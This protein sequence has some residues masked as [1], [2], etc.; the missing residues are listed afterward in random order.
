MS[1]RDDRL[2][3]RDFLKRSASLGAAAA[4]AGL[5]RQAMATVAPTS[6]RADEA[7]PA[8]AVGKPDVERR[9]ERSGLRYSRLGR[10]GF[11]V[12]ALSFGGYKL[13]GKT[14]PAFDA[15]VGSGVNF[16]MAH[17]G[18]CTQTLGEWFA[19]D[20]ARRGRIFLGLAGGPKGIDAELKA[21]GTDCVDLLMVGIHDPKAVGNENVRSHFEALRKA[22]KARFLCLVFHN[23]VPAVWQAGVKAGWYDVLLPTYNFASRA[24]LKDL[25]PQARSQDIGL[26]AMKASRGLGA[27]K[28][29]GVDFVSASKTFLADGIDSILRTIE[30]PT[31]LDQIIRLARRDDATAA[32]EAEQIDVTGQCALCGACEPCPAGV[33]IQDILRTWQY[34]A[35]DLECMDEAYRQY[36]AIPT[37]R[38]AAACTDCGQCEAHCPRALSVRRLIREAQTELELEMARR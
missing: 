32:A 15:A 27:G 3:R 26:L 37:A 5:A 12:S 4:A 2:A 9:N 33:A 10:T 7:P 19:K 14:R 30:T 23:H 20:K 29:K 18:A 31:Q 1:K 16:I 8:D 11:L 21:M 35:K 22:G 34:Y 36:A 6:R 28:A 24:D 25:I 17:A 38:L 13:S